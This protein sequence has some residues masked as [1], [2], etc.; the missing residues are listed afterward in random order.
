MFA[1]VASVP[2]EKLFSSPSICCLI[3]TQVLPADMLS[4]SVLTARVCVLALIF[5]HS[6]IDKNWSRWISQRQR[7]CK[8]PWG[9][10][11]YIMGD[12]TG[13]RMLCFLSSQQTP[14]ETELVVIW[15]GGEEGL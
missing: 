14:L 7:S 15:G 4:A 6:M 10:P 1:S 2:L 9:D 5:G 11:D 13:E 3:H 12:R 8:E